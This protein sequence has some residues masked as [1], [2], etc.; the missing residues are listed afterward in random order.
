MGL[1]QKIQPVIA[2]ALAAVEEQQQQQRQ[3]PQAAPVRALTPRNPH[4]IRNPEYSVKKEVKGKPGIAGF[5]SMAIMIEDEVPLGNIDP[6]AANGLDDE[7][8]ISHS[9]WEAKYGKNRGYMVEALVS[10]FQHTRT[11]FTCEVC[12]EQVQL[13][14]PNAL[15]NPL[16]SKDHWKNVTD[17][18][19][20]RVAKTAEACKHHMSYSL[21][22]PNRSDI[23]FNVNLYTAEAIMEG[24][25]AKNSRLS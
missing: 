16:F 18:V 2:A 13:D 14:N 24:E 19:Q 25:A 22:V 17:K 20:F 8:L 6:E 3:Q 23:T 4:A 21:C 11:D 15:P 5:R 7:G 10:C 1:V 12:C 9:R